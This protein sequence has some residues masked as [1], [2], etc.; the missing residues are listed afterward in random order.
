MILSLLKQRSTMNSRINYFPASTLFIRAIWNFPCH[1][2]SLSAD[3]LLLLSS[4]LLLGFVRL[5]ICATLGTKTQKKTKNKSLV[6][7]WPYYFI[8][9]ITTCVSSLFFF[10]FLDAFGAEIYWIQQMGYYTKSMHKR[11]TL[12]VI[13]WLFLTGPLSAIAVLVCFW[14]IEI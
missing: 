4:S 12:L 1:H 3:F 5:F 2:G 13:A 7:L 6:T 9:F 8:E 10:F 14:S 11:K